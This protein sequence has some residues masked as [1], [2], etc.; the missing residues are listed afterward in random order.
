MSASASRKRIT[1][2]DEGGSSS[3]ASTR[4]SYPYPR[5]TMSVAVPE[6]EGPAPKPQPTTATAQASAAAAA[7]HAAWDVIPSAPAHPLAAGGDAVVAVAPLED[8]LVAAPSA[9]DSIPTA[10]PQVDDVAAATG[11]DPVPAARSVDTVGVIGTVDARPV[12]L[13]ALAGRGID[14]DGDVIR[15]DVARR[16]GGVEPGEGAEPHPQLAVRV[17]RAQTPGSGEHPDAAGRA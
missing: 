8:D 7:S 2:S 11:V 13:W 16:P 1:V 12:R 10:A 4:S 3:L 17:R 6:D 15:R 5:V 9:V 14:A